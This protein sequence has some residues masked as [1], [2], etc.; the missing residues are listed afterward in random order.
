MS[1]FCAETLTH[2]PAAM[3]M[4]PASAPANPA[5]RTTDDVAPPPAKPRM[6]DT[7]DTSP[8]LTPNTAARATPP[9]TTR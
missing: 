5:S 4:P 9:V 7:F 1:S 3:L 8:S 6:S 2:S